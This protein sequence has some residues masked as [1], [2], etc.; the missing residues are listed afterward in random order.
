MQ[1][2][3][4]ACEQ[5]DVQFAGL[6]QVIRQVTAERD[7][8]RRELEGAGQRIGELLGDLQ[9]AAADPQTGTDF[10]ARLA[11]RLMRRVLEADLDRGS[12]DPMI[13]VLAQVLA[14]R[15]TAPAATQ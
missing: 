10:Q 8:A 14:E 9:V 4:E 1:E 15:D 11:L 2:R 6:H 7:E 12:D 3:N 13:Q 5:V